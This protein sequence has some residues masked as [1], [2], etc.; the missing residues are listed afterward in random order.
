MNKFEKH[1]LHLALENFRKNGSSYTEFQTQNQY[2]LFYYTEA[3]NYLYENEH[4]IPHSDNI[5]SHS[6]GVLPDDML[7]CYELTDEGLSVAK[8]VQDKDLQR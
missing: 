4:L 3:A 5:T 8:S 7:L 6:I 2:E 1:L